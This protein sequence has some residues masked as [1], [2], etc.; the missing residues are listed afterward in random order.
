MISYFWCAVWVWLAFMFG[1]LLAAL[2]SAN[3]PLNVEDDLK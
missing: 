3:D 2:M 1:F